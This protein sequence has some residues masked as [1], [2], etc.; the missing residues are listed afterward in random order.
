[1]AA[2]AL[3]VTSVNNAC[4]RRTTRNIGVRTPIYRVTSTA[5]ALVTSVAFDSCV[6]ASNFGVAGSSVARITRAI[7][8]CV[9]TSTLSVGITKI[10]RASV[11]II[12]TNIS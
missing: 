8:S 9:I 7:Y 11:V 5:F 10:I 4:I 12:A 2:S 3:R 1:M 6:R